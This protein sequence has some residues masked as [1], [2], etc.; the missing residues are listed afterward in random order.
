MTGVENQ[1]E[2]LS[3]RV[4]CFLGEAKGWSNWLGLH[5]EWLMLT[6]GLW[7]MQHEK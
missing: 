7:L 2:E 1:I 5:C 6:R 4:N 3:L